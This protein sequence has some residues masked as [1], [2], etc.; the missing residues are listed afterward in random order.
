MIFSYGTN[1][2]TFRRNFMS[3]F[4]FAFQ[5][6]KRHRIRYLA[7]IVTLFVVDFA[8]LFIPKLTGTITDGLTARTMNWQ[9]IK[10]CLLFFFSVWHSRS[11]VFSGVFSSSVLPA[12]LKR[13]C[14]TICLHIWKK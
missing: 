3:T 11:D 4:Q 2:F 6:I 1:K 13:N 14:E 12:P 7:G 5:Y 9:E 10:I 8:N